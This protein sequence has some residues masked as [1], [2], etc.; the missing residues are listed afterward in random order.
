MIHLR[1]VSVSKTRGQKEFKYE[2]LKYNLFILYRKQEI[3][4]YETVN[5]VCM[6]KHLDGPLQCMSGISYRDFVMFSVIILKLV[7]VMFLKSSN[8]HQ[9]FCGY[10]QLCMMCLR[11]LGSFS[12]E[13]LPGDTPHRKW[14]NPEEC[15]P[16]TKH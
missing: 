11:H 10:S 6:S 3:I 15:V 7:S 16:D 13:H 8:A 1:Q 5:F 4:L 2:D 12:G 9:S 14:Q